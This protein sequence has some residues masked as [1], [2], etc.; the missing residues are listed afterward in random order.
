L[1][2]NQLSGPLPTELGS[3]TNLT[4]LWLAGNQLSGEIPASIV[5]L[6]NLTTLTLS[7]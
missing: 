5:N 7:P 4:W 3:L 1:E 6:T 2:N